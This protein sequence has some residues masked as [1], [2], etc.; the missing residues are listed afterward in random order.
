MGARIKGLNRYPAKLQAL[1]NKSIERWTPVFTSADTDSVLIRIAPALEGVSRGRIE[2]GDIEWH[3]MRA[4]LINVLDNEETS[5]IVNSK[6]G[7]RIYKKGLDYELIEPT[8]KEWRGHSF[9]KIRRMKIKVNAGS[10]LKEGDKVLVSYDSL[11]LEYRAIPRSKYS[12]VS[13]YAYEEYRR[14]FRQFGRLPLRFIMVSFSEHFGGLNRDSRSKRLGKSNRSLL[15]SYMNTLERLLRSEG[16]VATPGGDELHGVGATSFRLVVWDDMLNPWHNGG[17]K[18]YQVAFGGPPGA[19]GLRPAS[20]MKAELSKSIWLASWWYRNDDKHGVIKN[21]PNFY[22][23]N[24][25]RYFVAAWNQE[26]AINDWL[27]MTDPQEAEGI[28][29]TTWNGNSE[30]VRRIAC[31]AWNKDGSEACTANRSVN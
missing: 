9:G 4:E 6:D 31:L 1:H 16:E 27:R 28:L 10:R 17:D 5:P 19:T 20:D 23:T 15:V 3:P 30:G 24:G 2:V 26:G 21:T 22:T 11:P 18:Y 12:G 7:K 29:A 25:Y 14:L 8:I 13:R